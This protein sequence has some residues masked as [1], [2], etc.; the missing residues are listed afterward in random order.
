MDK[1]EVTL[2]LWKCA[3]VMIYTEFGFIVWK[4]NRNSILKVALP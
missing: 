3:L 4:I 1:I 2:P